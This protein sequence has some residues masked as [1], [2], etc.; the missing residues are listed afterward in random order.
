M[1]KQTCAE[2][3][4]DTVGCVGKQIGAQRAEHRLEDRDR[5]QADDQHF[6]RAK[7]AMNEHLVDDDLEEERADERE[8]LQEERGDEHFAQEAAIFLDRA[9]EP[10]D[11]EAP[12]EVRERRTARHQNQTSIP[13]RL[14]FS[15]AQGFRTRGRRA[16]DH[17][18]VL[19]CLAE[20]EEIPILECRDC[21]QRRA[22]KARP[23][24]LDG[25][26]LEPNVFGAAQHLRDADHS[27]AQTM[28]ELL[29]L[30]RNAVHPQ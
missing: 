16:L 17:H 13:D 27:R 23:G 21:R 10:G 22:R 15:A 3:D 30:D 8:E 29:A 2:L 19:S 6:E 1:S 25:A 24:R 28:T 11:V 7:S 26:R 4:V 9:E 20:Q 14:E 5:H 18:Q 12:R